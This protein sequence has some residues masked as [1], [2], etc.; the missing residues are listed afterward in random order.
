MEAFR[1]KRQVVDQ[2]VYSRKAAEEVDDTMPAEGSNAMASES[3]DSVAFGKEAARTR[4][5]QI[6]SHDSR[7]SPDEPVKRHEGY[8]VFD[9]ARETDRNFQKRK[10]KQVDSLKR[11]YEEPERYEDAVSIV[12][13]IIRDNGSQLLVEDALQNAGCRGS[14][15]GSIL[16]PVSAGQ[17]LSRVR[18]D[19]A[20]S[21][22]ALLLVRIPIEERS[23][24][25]VSIQEPRGNKA[26]VICLKLLWNEMT[27]NCEE[28]VSM[29]YLIEHLSK[30]KRSTAKSVMRAL[31]DNGRP[32]SVQV[33]DL[34]R[35]CWPY[36]TE[37]DVQAMNEM[38]EEYMAE[39]NK[40][41]EIPLMT[42]EMQEGL[43]SVFHYTDIERRGGLT[44]DQLIDAELLYPDSEVHE[45]IFG[46]DGTKLCNLRQFLQLM[47]P[48]G[49]AL[50]GG[51]EGAAFSESQ[52]VSPKALQSTV[53]TTITLDHGSDIL[54]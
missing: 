8:R 23:R 15:F 7:E 10:R 51:W 36:A 29:V 33:E 2:E 24:V 18:S 26:F 54:E 48:Q 3:F 28:E 42:E 38:M 45:D 17:K 52:T 44:R 32:R 40:P 19:A 22:Q 46:E 6:S 43:I 49:Y 11:R 39:N 34:M 13:M 12:A 50:R 14:R 4:R 53:D 41:K 9:K 30:M 31:I 20:K 5:A 47:C 27:P 1:S 16:K 35:I 21:F 37:E 25:A